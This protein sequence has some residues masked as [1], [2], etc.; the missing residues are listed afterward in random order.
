MM[1]ICNMK[2]FVMAECIIQMHSTAANNRKNIRYT[3]FRKKIC[4]VI[5]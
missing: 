2:L 3:L 1:V 4:D 5:C